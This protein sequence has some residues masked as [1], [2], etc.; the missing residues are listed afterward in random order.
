[1]RIEKTWKI[2]LII[3]RP[4]NLSGNYGHRIGW[5]NGNSQGHFYVKQHD[6]IWVKYYIYEYNE[7]GWC[8]NEN[9]FYFYAS[10]KIIKY[11]QDRVRLTTCEETDTF[12]IVSR[13]LV[14]N[15]SK[16]VG[17]LK[18]IKNVLIETNRGNQSENVQ[19]G[20]K[21]GVYIWIALRNNQKLVYIHLAYAVTIEAVQILRRR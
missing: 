1:M 7:R 2:T 20:R 14:R 4:K 15:S 3:W 9:T 16:R 8:Q 12:S 21:I 10:R 5:C 13:R 19:L 18:K 6:W 17:R 11:E